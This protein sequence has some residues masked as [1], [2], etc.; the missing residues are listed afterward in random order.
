MTLSWLLYFAPFPNVGGGKW[1]S[2]SHFHPIFWDER[3]WS[4][5][6][7]GVLVLLVIRFPS[8]IP[9]WSVFT[10][11][12]YWLLILIMNNYLSNITLWLMARVH[13]LLRSA[14]HW[15]FIHTLHA[16]MIGFLFELFKKFWDISHR[17]LQSTAQHCARTTVSCPRFPW[18]RV[19]EVLALF[20]IFELITKLFFLWSVEMVELLPSNFQWSSSKNWYGSLKGAK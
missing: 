4:E 2:N 13:W 12:D 11:I 8:N 6:L 7:V 3:F 14:C 20:T 19:L 10:V 1:V 16:C 18:K 9:P 5:Y 15:V 17:I